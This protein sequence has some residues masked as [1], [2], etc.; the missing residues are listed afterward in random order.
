[1]QLLG[2]SPQIAF[3]RVYPYEVRYLAY[4]FNWLLLAYK[5]HRKSVSWDETISYAGDCDM[6]GP[7][8]FEHAELW[9]GRDLW[10]GCFAEAWKIFS[11][12]ASAKTRLNQKT[13]LPILYYA[14]KIPYWVLGPLRRTLSYRII[15]LVRDPRDVFLSINA[16]DKKRGFRGFNRRV[17]D[18]DW[19]FAARHA[20]ATKGLFGVMQDEQLRGTSIVMK[21]EQL[22]LDLKGESERLG[23]WLGVN[24]DASAVEN[25]LADMAHHMTSP[26]PAASIRRWEQ[27]LPPEL[28]DF[29]LRELSDEMRRFGYAA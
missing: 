10:R 11:Q 13:N 29:F 18:D 8:P 16:F 22:A 1:M 14:E 7:F 28:S 12:N 23:R 9:N 5:E 20:E 6:V 26:S 15:L 4:L 2:T 3:D 19:E 25:Q 17:D 27:E 24:F 21:Y